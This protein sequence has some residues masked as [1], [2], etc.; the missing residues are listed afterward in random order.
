MT[1][2]LQIKSNELNRCI[3][4][5]RKDNEELFNFIDK[6]VH[7]KIRDKLKWLIE[8]DNNNYSDVTCAENKLYFKEGFSNGVKMFVGIIKK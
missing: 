5:R 2:G 4:K 3:K 7:P 6:K 8:R 1:G